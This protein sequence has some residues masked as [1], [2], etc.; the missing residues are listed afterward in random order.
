MTPSPLFKSKKGMFSA[1]SVMLKLNLFSVLSPRI[2]LMITSILYTGTLFLFILYFKFR[3]L[4]KNPESSLC[5]VFTNCL[6]YL[7]ETI[8]AFNSSISHHFSARL[9]KIY[10]MKA[11]CRYAGCLNTAKITCILKIDYQKTYILP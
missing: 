3:N 7:K 5:T 10:Q 11:M 9:Y 2:T 4:A 6:L 8:F 1:A